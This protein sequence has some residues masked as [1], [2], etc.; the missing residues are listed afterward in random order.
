MGGV[1]Y[2]DSDR[3]RRKLLNTIGMAEM[4]LNLGVPVL[5]AFAEAVMRNASTSMSV[6]LQAADP[7]YFRVQRELQAMNLKQLVRLDPEPITAE[8]RISFARA[9]GIEVEEQLRIERF[10]ASWR[11]TISGCQDIQED[12]DVLTWSKNSMSTPEAWHLRE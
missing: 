10:L 8:A 7:M 9:F 1:K 12:Y 11:F 3:A 6:D 2:V 5:Q 4:V